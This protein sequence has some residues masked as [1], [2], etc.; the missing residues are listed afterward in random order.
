MEYRNAQYNIEN[1]TLDLEIE[2]PKYGWVPYT[3]NPDD[4]GGDFD[5]KELWDEVILGTVAAY[6]AP[7]NSEVQDQAEYSAREQRN[8]LLT[9]SDWTQMPDIITSNVMTST[10][11]AEWATYR[12]ALRDLPANTSDWTSIS[13]PTEPS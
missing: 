12:Q 13:W 5:A 11:Q 9:A 4:K 7:S 8:T 1:T 6:V 2:H 10:K 3:L